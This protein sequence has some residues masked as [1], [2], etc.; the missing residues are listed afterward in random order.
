[1]DTHLAHIGAAVVA[2]L[3]PLSDGLEVSPC[4]PDGDDSVEVCEPAQAEFWS[5]YVHLA[6]GGVDWVADYRTEADALAEARRLLR[7]HPGLRVNGISG[8]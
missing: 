8:Y 6:T 3:I 5:L 1:M 7:F 2:E 4:R